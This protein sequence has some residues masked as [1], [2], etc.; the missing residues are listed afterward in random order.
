VG[1]KKRGRYSSELDDALIDLCTH[2][3]EKDDWCSQYELTDE[4][5]RGQ[6]KLLLPRMNVL[7]KR[8]LAKLRREGDSLHYRLYYKLT[9]KGKLFAQKMGPIRREF[10]PARE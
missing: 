1:F 9:E 3:L 6:R 10:F 8:G 4:I 2:M 7:I 5:F